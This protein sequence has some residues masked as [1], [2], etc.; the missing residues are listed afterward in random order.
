MQNA[1]EEINIG[2]RKHDKI[3]TAEVD[4]N[5]AEKAIIKCRSSIN[6]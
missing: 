4:N 5:K 6:Y 3:K 1:P 2:N